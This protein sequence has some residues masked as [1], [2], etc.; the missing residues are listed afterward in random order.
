MKFG[1]SIC[2]Y[3]RLWVEA[4]KVDNLGMT[5]STALPSSAV[6]KS[7]SMSTESGKKT[8]KSTTKSTP[9]NKPASNESN[10][11][12][13]TTVTK[14]SVESPASG[15]KPTGSDSD[16]DDEEEEEEEEDEEEEEEEE[17]DEEEEQEEEEKED[18][19]EEED[20]EEEE[21]NWHTKVIRGIQ[22]VLTAERS[23]GPSPIEYM[24]V[25][26]RDK[27]GSY[28][29]LRED[30]HLDKPHPNQEFEERC[31]RKEEERIE[32]NRLHEVIMKDYIES[33]VHGKRRQCANCKKVEK[34]PGKYKKCERYELHVKLC[35]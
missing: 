18:E 6:L 10:S 5:S 24:E 22:S 30:F 11:S 8:T 13:N 29:R 32:G 12:S 20:E 3:L 7:K 1:G 4:G 25:Y 26:K 9:S 17:G 14:A 31:R 23:S 27:D 28:R 2:R 35:V 34:I 21:E 15:E 16:D 19:D 33:P